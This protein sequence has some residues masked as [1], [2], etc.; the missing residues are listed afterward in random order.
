ML[1]FSG[2]LGFARH[3]ANPVVIVGMSMIGEYP[4]AVQRLSFLMGCGAS[5]FHVFFVE[6][7]L[8]TSLE[9]LE[10][11]FISRHGDLFGS[12][13]SSTGQNCKNS[14]V[15]ANQNA[16]F[17]NAGKKWRGFLPLDAAFRLKIPCT[18]CIVFIPADHI[19]GDFMYDTFLVPRF[20][21][22]IQHQSGLMQLRVAGVRDINSRKCQ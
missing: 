18:P 5:G 7:L 10:N 12:S 20:R 21:L 3:P 15:E 22:E 6:N 9:C 8:L 16:S 2:G 14:A 19:S 13:T 4:G 11:G 17:C 1:T